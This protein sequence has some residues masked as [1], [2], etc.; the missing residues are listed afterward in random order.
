MD[1]LVPK[2]Q[3][4][5]VLPIPVGDYV[6]YQFYNVVPPGVFI[7]GIPLGL[8]SFSQGGADA[9]M[10]GF[11]AAADFLHKRGVHRIVQGGIPISAFIGRPRMLA[12]CEE[13]EKRTGIPCQADFDETIDGLK[14][15]GVRKVAIAAKWDDALINGMHGYL[16]HA[17]MEVVGHCAE[18]HTASQVMDVTPQAGYDMAIA[19]GDAALTKYPEAEGLLLGG[20]AWLSMTAVPV[21]E[22]NFG[23]PVVTNPNATYWAAMKQFGVSGR[24]GFGRLLDSL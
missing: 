9:A 20:G 19:L 12:I 14:S 2:H 4:G 16:A 22:A 11:A 24:K 7:V 21:L 17:G 10:E 5:Y 6:H 1:N 18:V 8:S 3:L 15:L 23:K 13:T